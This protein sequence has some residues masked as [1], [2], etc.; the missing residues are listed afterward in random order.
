MILAPAVPS[1]FSLS[2]FPFLLYIVP[3]LSLAQVL[4]LAFV[5][6]EFLTP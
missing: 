5:A 3:T 1:L 6:E 2:S 4:A